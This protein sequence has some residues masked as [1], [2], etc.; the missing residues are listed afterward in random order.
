MAFGMCNQHSTHGTDVLVFCRR[1]ERDGFEVFRDG[2]SETV[3]G[4]VFSVAATGVEGETFG[5]SMVAD[6]L[7]G[8]GLDNGGGSAA[9]FVGGTI[10]D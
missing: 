4:R 5:D 7:A 8:A 9:M 1:G 2:V 10:G 3:V 6:A